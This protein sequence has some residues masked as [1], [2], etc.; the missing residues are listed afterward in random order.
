MG[1]GHMDYDIACHPP[2]PTTIDASSPRNY[3]LSGFRA[4]GYLGYDWQ[5]ASQRVAF[6]TA[7]DSVVRTGWIIGAGL[8]A[9]V[10]GNWTLSGE[11]RY[12]YFGAWG[13]K[14][15]LSLPGSANVVGYRSKFAM[16]ILT[17]GV[18]Y[19]FAL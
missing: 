13:D 14:L 5:F 4:G 11:Y 1:Q 19:K 16:Q 8:E 9:R 17:L 6:S 3:D 15:N 2:F 12:A 7:T 18:A 10:W